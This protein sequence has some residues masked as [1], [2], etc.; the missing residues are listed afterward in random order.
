MRQ[1]QGAERSNVQQGGSVDDRQALACLRQGDI[2]AL[3]DLVARHQTSA[4]RVAY[5]ITRDRPLAEDIA[6][7]A[8][9]R[10]F[11]RA[12]QLR[13]DDAFRSWFLRSIANDAIKAAQRAQ[14][15][16]SLEDARPHVAALVERIRDPALEPDDLL[17]GNETR[18][19]IWVAL[20]LLTPAERAAIV[21]HDYLGLT[22][23]ETS[24]HLESPT[25]TIKWR[26]HRARQRLRMLMHPQ[27]NAAAQAHDLDHAP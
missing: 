18:A 26:L 17:T 8:F 21:L 27:A 22:I 25:G 19:E 7:S 14:R 6:Q 13:S 23:A 12:D 3:A 16:V 10:V 9:V 4:V 5:A 24:Q 20:G 11:E 15:H 2:S 1:A